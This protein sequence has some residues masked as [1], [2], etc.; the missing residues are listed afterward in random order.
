MSKSTIDPNYEKLFGELPKKKQFPWM[1]VSVIS[2]F[3]AV[4]IMLSVFLSSYL[5]VLHFVSY[6][7]G[8]SITDRKNDITYLLAPMCYEPIDYY[9]D[10]YAKYGDLQFHA[11]GNADPY[12]YLCTIDSGIYDLYYA[13][14]ITLP[15]FAEFNPYRIRI[16]EVGNIA[17][18]TG[19]VGEDNTK[20]IASYYVNAESVTKPM[21]SNVKSVLY[22]KFMSEE[23]PFMY[24]ILI[25]YTTKDGERYLYDRTTGRCVNLEDNFS[26]ILFD[27]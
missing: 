25:L 19:T 17:I 4:I 24:Y 11:I 27:K 21:S 3:L 6:D 7:S 13:D 5:G 2:L 9:K 16:C 26:D 10:V 20:D 23:Y 18:Q 8:S 14:T 12:K 15:T 22:L 1:L